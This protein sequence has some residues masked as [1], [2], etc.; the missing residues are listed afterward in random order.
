MS[1]QVFFLAPPTG[2]E[3]VTVG[4][5]GRCSIQLSYGGVACVS[6][7]LEGGLRRPRTILP[8]PVSLVCIGI[9][10]AG[11]SVTKVWGV[12]GCTVPAL[13]T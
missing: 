4:L 2:F 7:P 12:F 11:R 9:R 6:T 10:N 5:E 13:S 3:P 1:D 8:V